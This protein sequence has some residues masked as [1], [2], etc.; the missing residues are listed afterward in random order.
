MQLPTVNIEG[1]QER[2]N[3]PVDGYIARRSATGTK[4]DTPLI[5]TPQSISVITRDQMAVQDAQTVG[6]AM[7]YT[8]GV[9]AESRAKIGG[10]AEIYY[11]RGFILDRYLNGLQVQ[12]S[13]GFITP[14]FDP[15]MLERVEVL[16]GPSSVLYGANTP[17]GLVNMVSKMP[18]TTPLYDFMF[19]AGN[20]QSFQG[21]FDVG[22]PVAGSDTLFY[23]L[24]GIGKTADNQV[25]YTNMQRISIAPALTWRPDNDTTITLLLN[26]QYD[27]N[28]GL[29]NF[30]PAAGTVTPNINGRIGAN[31]FAGEPNFNQYERQQVSAGYM[32][33][34]R[35]NDVFTVRQNFRY[36]Y[37]AGAL[38]QVLPAA[39]DVDQAT[40][41]RYSAADKES[42]GTISLDN[43]GEARFS[44]GPV[45][46]T[47]LA[48]VD[49]QHT[50]FDGRISSGLAGDLNVYAPVYSQY[51][52]TLY[53]FQNTKQ[54][55]D[56][57]GLYA[58][59]QM[60]WGRVALVLSGRED[61]AN[62]H[63]TDNLVPSVSDQDDTHFSGRVGLVYLFDNG[64]APYVS[65]STSFQPTIG[66]NASG[67]PFKPTTGEQWE[68][69][70]KYQPP[71]YTSFGMVSLYNLTQQNALTVDPNNVLFQTQTGEIRSR[72]V[73]LST[74]LNLFDGFNLIGA[75]AYND[76][77]VT[78]SNGP[79][80]DKMPVFVPNTL[81]SGW[82]DYTVQSGALEGVQFGAGVRYVGWTF[83]DAANTL[84]VPSY[85]L[86]DGRIGYD[87]SKLSN[88][89]QGW[90]VA[91]NGSNLLNTK[92]VSSCSGDVNCVIGLRR[93]IL[94]S[95]RK[96]F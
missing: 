63:T 86:V 23:R 24:T 7:R 77:T 58:Q 83:G 70:M 46:H 6:Q 71:G 68:V 84:R 78:K 81:A 92:Y 52:D 62:S 5:E 37:T 79:D 17:G 21:G 50:N 74:T 19:Q 2:A 8:A 42:T 32:A 33:E 4:T 9:E 41:F 65:Y 12:G 95:V 96:T 64:I 47:I 66:V 15:Y 59:D 29:Y 94:A 31:L 39:L 3:G 36:L 75:F 55:L 20:R 1:Q 28:V 88:E 18:T 38:G 61:W 43:Q 90:R 91:L 80:K 34:H 51:L 56:Q 45:R 26:Y 49:F 30:V 27:P 11:G 22:G 57:F 85:T 40:L 35:F 93:T 69:G 60:R 73:E 72:G 14:A 44:T 13:T 67:T 87:L 89:L 25:D 16:R 48:G 76:P 82:G 53:P 10:G 54:S